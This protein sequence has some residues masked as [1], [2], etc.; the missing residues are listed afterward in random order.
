MRKRSE[1]V[2]ESLP[3]AATRTLPIASQS[4]KAIRDDVTRQ[5]LDISR[6]IA[7]LDELSNEINATLAFLK[8]QR[9]DKI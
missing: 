9:G 6:T 1:V 2:P 4:L 3:I 5:R 7:E 8:T